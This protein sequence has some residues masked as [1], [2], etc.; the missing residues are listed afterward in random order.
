MC[1]ILLSGSAIT[2]PTRIGLPRIRMSS[3]NPPR[4]GTL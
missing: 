1:A 3:G 2:G 4:N